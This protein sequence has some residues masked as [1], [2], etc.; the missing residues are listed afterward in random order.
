VAQAPG[1]RFARASLFPLS[2]CGIAPIPIDILHVNRDRGK[3]GKVAG[4]LIDFVSEQVCGP[5][6]HGPRSAWSVVAGGQRDMQE[7]LGTISADVC[8]AQRHDRMLE[9]VQIDHG[10]SRRLAIAAR[11]VLHAIVRHHLNQMIEQLLCIETC[12]ALEIL[13]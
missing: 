1:L 10:D 2:R 7:S 3:P 5:R 11:R 4:E 8:V 9:V 13:G 6:T 12:M